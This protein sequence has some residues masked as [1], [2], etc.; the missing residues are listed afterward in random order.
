LPSATRL[1]PLNALRC[2]EAAARHQHFGRA[3]DELHLTHGAISRAV[4]LL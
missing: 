1:P 2:F 4:S 3:G